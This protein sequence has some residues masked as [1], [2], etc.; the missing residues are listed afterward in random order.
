MM[1]RT[2]H[3]LIVATLSVGIVGA[4]CESAKEAGA[5]IGA[6]GGGARR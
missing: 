4:G 1:T 2:K 5:A 6:I 3:A